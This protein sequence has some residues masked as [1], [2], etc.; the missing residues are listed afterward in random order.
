[1]IL[2][3]KDGN[4][5]QCRK[6]KRPNIKTFGWSDDEITIDGLTVIVRY[7]FRGHNWY[8]EHNKVWYVVNTANLRGLEL[9]TIKG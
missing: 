5:Y 3:D 7:W 4:K 9:K 8:F 6:T 1:M 2:Y